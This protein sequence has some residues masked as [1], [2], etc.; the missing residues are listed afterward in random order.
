MLNSR[1]AMWM[2]LGAGAH[3]LLQRRLPADARASS[4]TGPWAR[5]ATRSGRRSGRTSARAS[6]RV[7]ATGE[8][9]WDEGLLLF[10]ERSGYPEETY[11]TFS[12][13]PVLDDDGT[14]R[15][16]A[17]RRH[18]GD[19]A[20][21]RRAAAA[22]LRELAAELRPAET[23]EDSA[24]AVERGAGAQPQGPAV[25]ACSTC[26]RRR[27]PARLA[28]PHGLA[29]DRPA[30]PAAIDLTRP[31]A[32]WPLAA[33]IGPAGRR[34]VVV[35]LPSAS[36]P[37]PAGAWPEPP[38][39]AAARAAR[40]AGPGAPAGLSGRRAQSLPAVRRGLPRVHRAGR[41][42]GRR[43]AIANAHAYEEERRRAEALA[44]L[45]RA[46]TAFFSNVS[47]EFRTPLTLMLGPLED[48][49]ADRRMP[50]R[51]AASGSSRVHRNGLRLLKLVN[52]LLD[53]SR[54]E[55]GRVAGH[56]TSRPTWPRSPPTWP[57]TSARPCERAGLR[58]RASTARRCREPVYV[59]R[60]MW[61]K[62]VLNLL[63][64]AFKFTFEGA[65]SVACAVGADGAAGADGARHRHRH[66]GGRAAAPVRAVPPRRGRARPQHEG[67]GIGLGA[68]AGAGEAARRHLRAS[69][70]RSGPGSDVHRHHSRSGTRICR[71][72]G[73]SRRPPHRQRRVACAGLCRGGAALAARTARPTPADGRAARRPRRR[74]DAGRSR[75]R[76]HPA[77][78]RQRRHARVRA[79]AAR[80]RTTRSR[81]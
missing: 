10:L 17:L 31:G 48:A 37:L 72:T 57:A 77:G 19:R 78:R 59:D 40:A 29:A 30:R 34:T 66:P 33:A 76:P 3:V 23:E 41:R 52:T 54:I 79:P 14:R 9:T 73:S 47:H 64:N 16:H 65:I 42:P 68:G 13:S 21:H 39:Q 45:D 50:R 35:D 6:R 49:L 27:R 4:A 24:A 25:R 20:R 15:R 38:R 7:L 80:G 51:R 44:E 71:P 36:A 12:Y 46:K 8:A 1:Y 81:R 56:A 53:F 69:R 32:P 70:A 75:P 18:R 62:I 22:T 11:H 61:E 28:A 43:R 63:S 55:A 74:P 26:S 58:L 60:D 5:C 2:A 67:S